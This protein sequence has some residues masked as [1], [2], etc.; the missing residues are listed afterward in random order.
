MKKVQ[1]KTFN[2]KNGV[3]FSGAAGL[4][5]DKEG[6][7]HIWGTQ[8]SSGCEIVVNRFSQK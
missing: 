7:L 4:Q 6:K 8:K 5:G 3:D 1:T 2:Y